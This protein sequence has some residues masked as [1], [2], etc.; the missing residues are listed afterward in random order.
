VA[1][2]VLMR[3]LRL[4][5]KEHVESKDFNTYINMFCDGLS[6][7]QTQLIDMLFMGKPPASP[8]VVVEEAK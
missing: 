7:E 8:G 5:P 3:K 1:Q 4:A 6:I 2:N